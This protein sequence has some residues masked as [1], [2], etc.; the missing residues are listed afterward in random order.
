MLR[1]SVSTNFLTLGGPKL[2]FYPS[3]VPPDHQADHLRTTVVFLFSERLGSMA[4]PIP[5]HKLRGIAGQLK[6]EISGPE[7]GKGTPKSL[8]YNWQKG[9]F[10][11]HPEIHRGNA[12]K[13][14]L[15]RA[16]SVKTNVDRFFEEYSKFRAEHNIPP[17][18]CGI[19]MSQ[20][21]TQ[22]PRM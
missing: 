8:S 14:S 10:E 22:F 5:A 7:E 6:S 18:G 9:F 1:E 17:I 12:R 3:Y 20:V 19:W 21:L 2:W 11:R 16:I 15:A 4:F 13:L